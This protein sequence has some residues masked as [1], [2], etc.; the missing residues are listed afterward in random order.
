MMHNH[1][2]AFALMYDLPPATGTD[3]TVWL[4][5]AA[6]VLSLAAMLYCL[7]CVGT[8]RGQHGT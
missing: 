5:V 1:T 4:L 2:A 3:W 7:H 6:L 8:D